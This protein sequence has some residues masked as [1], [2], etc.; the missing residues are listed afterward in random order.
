MVG[1]VDSSVLLLGLALLDVLADRGESVALTT[2]ERARDEGKSP[3][4][5]GTSSIDCEDDGLDVALVFCPGWPVTSFSTSRLPDEA[6]ST[7]ILSTS[8]ASRP[9][10]KKEKKYWKQKLAIVREQQQ[11]LG[12][13]LRTSSMAYVSSLSMTR[14]LQVSA[15]SIIW[16]CSTSMTL[17][18]G[19]EIFT[20]SPSL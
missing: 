15:N 16:V 7:R 18:I 3:R 5:G 4:L 6:S 14:I 19:R 12:S 20:L 11:S 1:L 2:S 13:V 9:K 17:S 10:V 8:M